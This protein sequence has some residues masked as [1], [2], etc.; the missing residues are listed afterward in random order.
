[1]KVTVEISELIVKKALA[2]LTVQAKDEDELRMVSDVMEYCK[3]HPQEISVDAFGDE[4]INLGLALCSI[5]VA[6]RFEETIIKI[7]MKETNVT[8]KGYDTD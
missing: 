4:A 6:E 5:V 3:E 1:M 2:F 7:I 8:S